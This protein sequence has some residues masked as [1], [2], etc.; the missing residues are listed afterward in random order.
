MKMAIAA[1]ISLALSLTIS[2]GSAERAAARIIHISD[3]RTIVDVSDPQISPNGKQIVSVLS[4]PN[5]AKNSTDTKLILVDIATKA[6]RAAVS[7]RKDVASPRWSPSGD[8]IAFVAADGDKDD[9]K[10]QVFILKM[11][12]GSIGRLTQAP[13][14][15]AAFAW[16][17]DGNAIA[18][19]SAD[20]PANKKA[21][22]NHHDWFEVGN[23]AYLSTEAPTPSHLWL[24]PTDGGS[25]Q[26]ITSGK[27]SLP[28]GDVSTPLSWSPDG[29]YIA[30]TKAPNAHLGDSN[31]SYI[32]IVDVT[33]R[34]IR[35]L[36]NH[37]AFEGYSTFSPDGSKIAYW[38]P[39]DGNPLNGAE[40]RVV[41]AGG[42]NGRPI[43]A[44][45]DRDM[46]RSIWMPDGNS[47]LVGGTDGTRVSLWLQPLTGKARKLNLGEVNPT[48]D[49]WA[50]VNLG[51]R[52]AIALSGAEPKRPTELYYMSSPT[53]PLRRLT[54]F[55]GHIAALQLGK[56]ETI[57]WKSPEGFTEDGVLIYPPNFVRGRKYPMVLRIHG[58]PNSAATTEFWD[59]VQLVAAR[60]YLV[61]RPN[62]RGSDDLGN[63]YEYAIFN[64]AG[65]GP[66]R[67]VMLGVK[68]V[69]AMGIV[70]SSRL[71][72]GGWS[73]GGYMTAWLV[74]HYPVWKVDVMGAAETDALEQ[75]DL[76]DY[77]VAEWY[78]FKGSPWVDR[79]FMQAYIEQSP[80]TYAARI[81]T[82]TLILSNTGDIRVPN[83]QSFEIFHALRDNHVPVK[84]IVFP[85]SGHE[86]YGPVHIED[87]YRIWLDWLDKYLK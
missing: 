14:G 83:T 11:S 79:R 86:V 17:P 82:P 62:Y 40:V 37:R 25:A 85:E 7:D 29:R 72:V 39:K 69:E 49:Y 12:D 38:Y 50:D 44:A 4:S 80:M 81:K 3:V 26:R 19:V 2:L 75:Y 48:W 78:Y 51:P 24:I 8:R 30:I 27:W 18:Y 68:T 67:D 41:S 87:M 28:G 52:G 46:T 33:T 21:I 35:K 6:Y 43:T 58:G 45:L 34:K 74:G 76:S 31:S 5:Y 42:G 65:D 71:A 66:G 55:N 57:T 54:N 60:G 9:A 77:N 64:D 36:S 20:E 59:Y 10:S 16:R 15:I 1:G 32:A 56:S 47:L 13:N 61:F 70:D 63:A 84:F 73:Y 23:D 53:A 22:Q